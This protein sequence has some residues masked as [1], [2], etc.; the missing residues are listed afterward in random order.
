MRHTTSMDTRI[1]NLATRHPLGLERDDQSRHALNALPARPDCR[2][3]VIGED[4]VRDPL[5]CAVH[6]IYI[7]LSRRR[8][9]N[10]SNIGT[11]CSRLAR[12]PLRWRHRTLTVWLRDTQAEPMIPT[13]H[14]RQ[15]ATLLLRVSKVDD[16]GAAD[17]V[18]TSK[19]PDYSQVSAASQLIDDDQVVEAVPFVRVNIAGEALTL[20]VVGGE[21]KRR[22]GRVSELGMASV[23]LL[24]PTRHSLDARCI[25]WMGW[26][27]RTSAGTSPCF[28]HSS[29]NGRI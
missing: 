28:S 9:R 29:Q 13:Q 27:R 19:R 15:E 6:D 20:E 16:G 25:R 18:A 10:P 4:A 12:N 14:I 7:A 17:R 11:S 3:A 5:L 24:R 2:G 23:N 8:G 26:G 21:G 22:D 1:V